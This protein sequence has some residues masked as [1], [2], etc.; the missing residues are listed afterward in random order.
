MF[1]LISGGFAVLLPL[2]DEATGFVG[3][4]LFEVG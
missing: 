3:G 1:F 4:L 2:M